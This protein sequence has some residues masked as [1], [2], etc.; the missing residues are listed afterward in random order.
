MVC[1]FI[2]GES[3]GTIAALS[4]SK[5]LSTDMINIKDI[6]EQLKKQNILFKT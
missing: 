6:Q 5:D 3:A 4:L 2:T 1:C